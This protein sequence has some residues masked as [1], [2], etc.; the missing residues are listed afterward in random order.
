MLAQEFRRAVWVASGQSALA[1][2]RDVIG[3]AEAQCDHWPSAAFLQVPS[4]LLA[5]HEKGIGSGLNT[6]W[7]VYTAS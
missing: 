4:S 2:L 5:L 3:T 7:I 6:K 1:D